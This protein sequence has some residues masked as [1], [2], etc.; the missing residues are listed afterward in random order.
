MLAVTEDK[1]RQDNISKE[2]TDTPSCWIARS[3][4][5]YTTVTIVPLKIQINTVCTCKIQC[6]SVRMLL[7]AAKALS[8]GS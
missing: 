6:Q 5:K 3:L 1:T 4:E 7:V 8:C 2:K